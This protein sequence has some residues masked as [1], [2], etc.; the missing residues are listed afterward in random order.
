MI[1]SRERGRYKGTRWFDT[2]KVDVLALQNSAERCRNY[3]TAAQLYH[4]VLAP[5][6]TQWDEEV[7]ERE[8]NRCP[9][10][11]AL[12]EEQCYSKRGCYAYESD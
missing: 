4:E 11:G 3:M 9:Q 12:P 7:E 10:C 6:L 5:F 8:M 1:A 2:F